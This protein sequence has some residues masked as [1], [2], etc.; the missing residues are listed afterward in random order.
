ML[1]A[2]ALLL[3]PGNLPGQAASSSSSSQSTSVGNGPASASAQQ[4]SSSTS[5]AQ[6]SLGGITLETSEPLF[7]L[8]AALNLCGYDADLENSSPV[9]MEVRDDLNEALAGSAPARDDRDAL[10][11]FVRQH[12]LT[13]SSQDLE[14]YVA[15]SL[16][17]SQPPELAPMV[18]EADMPPYAADI[19]NILPLLRSFAEAANLHGIWIKHRPE[20]DALVNQL[21]N[22][23][24]RM[25]LDTNVSLH[26][27][28][29]SYDGRRFVV[30][31]EPLLSPSATN[32]LYSG[33]DYYVVTSPLRQPAATVRME[34]IRHTYLH[35]EIEP[36]V[37]ARTTAMDRLLPLLRTVQQAPLDFTYKSDIVSLL[38]ECL[39]KAIE[40]RTMDVGLVKPTRPK[41][42]ERVDQ[43]RYD[44]A[45]SVYERQAEAVRRGVVERDMRQGWVLTN[46]FYEQLGIMER[47]STSLS[48]NIGP[49]IYGMDVD[50]ERKRALQIDFLPTSSSDVVRRV[51]RQPVGMDLAEMK[52]MKGDSDGAEE[53]ATRT[54][55][56]PAGD[57]GR[58]HYLL[59]RVE[60]LRGN[61]DEA[62][63]HFQQ[64]L[65]ISKD[66][67]T[68]AWSHIYLG[69]LY[70]TQHVPDRPKAVEEYK[71][72]LAAR[73][74]QPDTKAAAELGLQKPFALPKREQSPPEDAPIDPTGKAEKDAY[75]PDSAK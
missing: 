39:I 41:G 20:Y 14:Q 54:L 63:D 8:A 38:A 59:A 3:V 34:H 24:T 61:P 7:D 25:I 5:R 29:S 27:P 30:L 43:E 52:L 16:Y 44:A 40:A 73:D 31:L 18:A 50:D 4:E 58:A 1:A 19:L 68:L 45:M 36:L 33:V 35:Y 62:M 65:K 12:R 13:D 2:A 70:D 55:A 74:A 15:L 22:P 17:L 51:P 6:P 56:E 47:E 11:T 10:C 64:A 60:L 72:A 57:H 67:R 69:R 32:A 21:H 71:A 37:Y 49:M 23:L 48:E 46:Y 9:R 28:L 53:I 66:P 26:Q 75:R 42:K